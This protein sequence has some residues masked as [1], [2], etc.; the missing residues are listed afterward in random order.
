MDINWFCHIKTQSLLKVKIGSFSL[1]QVFRNIT[2]RNALGSI[3]I[4]INTYKCIYIFFTATFCNNFESALKL[5]KLSQTKSFSI[6][7]K[8][9]LFERF[10]VYDV[11]FKNAIN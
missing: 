6:H 4:F 2:G 7:L 11:I 5:S 10:W 9:N 3:E 1:K 8:T